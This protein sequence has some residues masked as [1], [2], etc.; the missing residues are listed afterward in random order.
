M[1]QHTRAVY[2]TAEGAIA[3]AEAAAA[4]AEEPYLYSW[5]FATREVE[6]DAPPGC[7]KIGEC[8]CTIPSREDAPAVALGEIDR[9]IEET[10]QTANT[11]V[12]ELRQ[13]RENL[14]A[15]TMEVR[16]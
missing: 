12:M 13:R 9:K 5:Y 3:L 11:A 7:R 14:L 10:Y 2:L 16:T 4:G 15:I 6:E 1:S 8:V